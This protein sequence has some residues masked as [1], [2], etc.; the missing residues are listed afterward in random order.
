MWRP[1]LAAALLFLPA[2]AGG[3]AAEA[4]EAAGSADPGLE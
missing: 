2:S 3:E 4:V 1:L